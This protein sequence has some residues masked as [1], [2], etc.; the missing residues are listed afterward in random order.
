[1]NAFVGPHDTT[2]S[3]LFPGWAQF[4]KIST[5][6]NP[7]MIFVFLDE[8]PDFI[9][10]GWYVYSNGDPSGFR[11]SDMPA[12]YHNGAAGFS[13]ADGHSEIKRWLVA[14]T[15]QAHY[16]TWPIPAGSDKRDYSWV[17]ERASY[18]Q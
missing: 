1:M 11:W 3:L 17:M 5:I 7:T 13:F 10:D 8:H 12:S 6:R 16:A 18:R 14:T 2:G 9:N 4:I 15:Q